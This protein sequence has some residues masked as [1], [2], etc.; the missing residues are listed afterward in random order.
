MTAK[1]M[2]FSMTILMTCRL[3]APSFHF[4]ALY[5]IL[6]RRFLMINDFFNDGEANDLFNDYF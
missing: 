2:T 4:P 5:R 1:P 3:F 6:K